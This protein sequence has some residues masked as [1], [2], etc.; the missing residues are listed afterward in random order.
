MIN[1]AAFMSLRERRKAEK[2]Q[3]IRQA[4]RE[5]FAT[6]GF[7]ETPMREVARIAD[8]GFGTVSAYASDKAGL[9]AMLLVEDLEQLDPLFIEVRQKVPLL[10]QV[11]DNFAISFRFWAEKPELSRVVLP[12]LGNTESPYIDPIMRRR[13]SIRAALIAWLYQFKHQ[14]LI[15]ANCNLEQAGELLFALYVASINE[16]LSAHQ[17]DPET[18]IERMRYLMEIPVSA[19][20][21]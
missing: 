8:V 9:A 12:M 3:A 2:F 7:H 1:K 6:H 13:A 15:K 20:E 21:S 19:F 4:A 16:W 14:G 18:G 10:D 17:L 11:V 5:L